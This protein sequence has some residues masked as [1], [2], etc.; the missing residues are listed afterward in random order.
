MQ[1][2][3]DK[4]GGAMTK[5]QAS[6]PFIP[7]HGGKASPCH[8]WGGAMRVGDSNDAHWQGG[9]WRES[10]P[11]RGLLAQCTSG[12]GVSPN[13]G[14]PRRQRASLPVA[15]ESAGRRSSAPWPG[16]SSLSPSPMT[17]VGQPSPRRRAVAAKTKVTTA[18]AATTTR[19]PHHAAAPITTEALSNVI[20]RRPDHTRA[21]R[22]SAGPRSPRA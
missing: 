10:S 8:C 17:R 19:A 12:E 15:R 5:S 2:F 7:H 3:P 6:L 22:V 18:P 21:W 20:T 1:N 13:T 11:R 14:T 9:R 16:E 4:L